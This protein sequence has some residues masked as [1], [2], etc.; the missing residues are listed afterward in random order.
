MAHANPLENI[1]NFNQTRNRNL[2]GPFRGSPPRA[3]PRSKHSTRHATLRLRA[4]NV[5]AAS[6]LGVLDV[7]EVARRHGIQGKGT[8]LRLSGVSAHSK[9]HKLRE[10]A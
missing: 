6:C 7:E 3:N 4:A 9:G 10:R 5:C 1:R 2:N 8:C